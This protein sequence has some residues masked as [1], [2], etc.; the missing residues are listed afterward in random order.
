MMV[1]ICVCWSKCVGV[2]MI[3]YLKCMVF[4]SSRP[5]TC[6]LFKYCYFDCKMHE[7]YSHIWSTTN[8]HWPWT[9]QYY[10]VPG[11]T[12][13]FITTRM[14]DLNVASPEVFRETLAIGW[15]D[16][17]PLLIG[18]DRRGIFSVGWDGSRWSGNLPAVISSFLLVFL[19][20]NIQHQ[21]WASSVLKSQSSERVLRRSS[22]HFTNLE[23]QS[24]LGG[25]LAE[26]NWNTRLKTLK[27]TAR[28]PTLGKHPRFLLYR[29]AHMGSPGQRWTPPFIPV[30]KCFQLIN[31]AW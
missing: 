30:L 9:W 29:R 17:T 4:F 13:M 21:G 20:G 31:A 1:V 2:W 10:A 23:T 14:M 22:R 28:T 3:L 25:I 19:L 11:V 5:T 7:D 12:E 6:P 16:W 27:N 18:G 15:D 24:T 8:S 26:Y